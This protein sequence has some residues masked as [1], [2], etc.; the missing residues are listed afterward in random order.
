MSQKVKEMPAPQEQIMVQMG[1]N[2][3]HLHLQ[4]DIESANCTGPGFQTEKLDNVLCL[5][6]PI[7]SETC[8]PPGTT[9]L[10]KEGDGQLATR[11]D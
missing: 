9:Q 3:V 8:H 10:P 6:F 1:W 11:S 4:T 7:Q 2:G 5:P